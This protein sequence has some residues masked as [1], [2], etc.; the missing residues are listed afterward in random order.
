[1]KICVLAPPEIPIPLGDSSCTN[2]PP[3]TSVNQRFSG[4]HHSPEVRERIRRA[5]IGQKHSLGRTPW[6]K[7]LNGARASKETRQKMSESQKAR[8]KL[9]PELRERYRKAFVEK[10]ILAG[11]RVEPTKGTHR[12]ITWG[13]KIRETVLRNYREHPEII[14]KIR[15]KRATQHFPFH[16]SSIEARVAAELDSAGLPYAHPYFIRGIGV[17][18]IDF[19]FPERR[20]AL[21]VHG[22]YWHG[23]AA[24]HPT[25]NPTKKLIDRRNEEILSQKGW[26]VR[27]VW[28]HEILAPGFNIAE[29]IA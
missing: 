29:V 8:Y 11:K 7:G 10:V 14:D 5:I 16:D 12:S 27:T 22:C 15:E 28:E 2:D 21:F 19:A 24:H 13:E 20:L 25:A 18:S 26:D 6:N 9:N 3:S 4:H 17:S 1:M 23:C